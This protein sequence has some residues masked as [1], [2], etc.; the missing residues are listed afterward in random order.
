MKLFIKFLLPYWKKGIIPVIFLLISSGLS[1]IYPMFPKWAIDEVLGGKDT[2]K[3]TLITVFFGIVIILSQLFSYI[4]RITF[5]KFQKE[6]ILD[7]QKKLLEKVFNYPMEYFDKNH[8]GY[9]IGRIRGDVTGLSYIFSE[10]LIMLM[11]DFMKF[12]ATIIILMNMNVKLTLISL[13]IT[14]FLIIKM[15]VSR[16]GIESVNK[17]ILEENARAEKEL[18]DIFQGI[19]V[20]KSHSKEEEGIERAYKALDGYQKIEVKRNIVVSKYTLFIDFFVNTGKLLLL[21]FGMREIIKGNISVGGYVAFAGYLIYLYSPLQNISYSSIYL[22]YAKRSY[23]RI[24]ELF[25]ILPEDSGEKKI[26]EIDSVEIRNLKFSY[27]G[28]KEIIK[29]LNFKI[30][31]GEKVV[32]KGESGSGKSTLV[33]LLLGLYKPKGGS[34]YYNGINLK[35]LDLK[36]LGTCQ[37]SCV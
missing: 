11:M 12:A 8:S 13:S 1:L 14:P 9:L 6:S 16:D 26:D 35:E 28:E 17:K 30:K 4:N 7:I 5:F 3:I 10:A 19:E 29:G 25:D 23:K 22:D 20:I 21:Y 37:E 18:S 15:F 27:D 2:G 31:K 32:I 24:K 36:R 34:I 33:K